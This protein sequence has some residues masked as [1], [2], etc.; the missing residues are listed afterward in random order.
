MKLDAVSR[1]GGGAQ[2]VRRHPVDEP[3]LTGLA[4]SRW[5]FVTCLRLDAVDGG[6]GEDV[7]VKALLVG[8]RQLG[9]AADPGGG[10]QLHLAVVDAHQH[11]AGRGDDDAAGVCVMR[12]LLNVRV[13][14]APA[15]RPLCRRRCSAGAGGRFLG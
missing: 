10:P 7:D 12:Q 14:R 13:G 1:P 5:S 15:A 9:I 11:V 6:G 3:K 2:A 8:R 4:A